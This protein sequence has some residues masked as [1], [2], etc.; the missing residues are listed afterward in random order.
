MN[1]LPIAIE[2]TRF[3]FRF[4]KRNQSKNTKGEQT[5]A[6][7][8][9]M[10]PE[11]E[12][13]HLFDTMLPFREECEQCAHDLHVC[14]TCS[15]YDRYAENQCREPTADPVSQKD[16]RN[17]CEYWKPR[18]SGEAIEG[19]ADQAKAKLNAL[20][21]GATKTAPQSVSSPESNDSSSGADDS[22]RNDAKAKLDALFKK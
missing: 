21:G 18:S 10:C 4:N 13:P 17:L 22:I 14:L 8:E 7:H 15:F 12:R 1:W 19:A 5:M 11:C 3:G 9:I 20:F 6:S 2:S 16:R